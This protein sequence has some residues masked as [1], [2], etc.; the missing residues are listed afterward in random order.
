MEINA[1]QMVQFWF[2]VRP[3]SEILIPTRDFPDVWY[4][5]RALPLKMEV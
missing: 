5:E 4:V 2:P 1:I 3:P